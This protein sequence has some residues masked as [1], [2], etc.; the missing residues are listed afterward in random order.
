[1][2]VDLGRNDVGRVAGF[3]TVR[4]TEL[5]GVE[6]Y[7][8][9]QHLVSEVRGWLRQGYDALDALKACFPGGGVTG[10]PKVRAMELIDAL[11]P[12]RRGAR[13]GRCG[14]VGRGRRQL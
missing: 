10:A 5:M 8:H 14:Y 3:G 11:R 2:L 9:V 4:V 6:R 13:H 12:V 7:S 1:M